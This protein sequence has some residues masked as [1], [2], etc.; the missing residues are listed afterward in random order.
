MPRRVLTKSSIDDFLAAG[1]TE[2][3]LEP[4][5]IV[6]A[7]AKEYAQ[8][9]GVRLVPAANA[10][11]GMPRAQQPAAAPGP[12]EP[13]V[14]PAEPASPADAR[15][16]AEQVRKAVIA[17]IGDEPDGL[18]AIISRVLRSGPS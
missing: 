15:V 10:A 3:L 6:T 8:Q 13:P 14:T 1:T 16:D 18:G 17:A 11:G 7:L 4:A 9:R 12:A 2:V 5:D